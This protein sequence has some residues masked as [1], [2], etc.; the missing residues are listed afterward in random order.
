MRLG[1]DR[2]PLSAPVREGVAE[3][4]LDPGLWD[5]RIAA[6]GHQP[7]HHHL[8]VLGTGPTLAVPLT[9]QPVAAPPPATPPVDP[10]A[11]RRAG[12]LRRARVETIV[13]A[14]ALPVGLAALGGFVAAV[15]YRQDTRAGFEAL[16]RDAVDCDVRAQLDGL[17]ARARRETGAMIALGVSA[18]A[19]LTTGAVLLVRGQRR[20][21]RARIALDLRPGHAGL[22]LSG[23][24]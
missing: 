21:K 19:L 13:G 4:R 3:L 1:D 18:G 17:H 7:L 11:P 9:L 15:A 5:L 8:D 24:F 10:D 2:P 16:R 20:M 22:S 23:A 6:A 14:V 12:Q